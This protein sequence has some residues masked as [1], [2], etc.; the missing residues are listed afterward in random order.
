MDAS[1]QSH[2]CAPLAALLYDTGSIP[3]IDELIG[4]AAGSNEFALSHVPPAGEGWA[5]VLRDG[6]TFDLRGLSG[7]PI[8]PAPAI[9]LALGIDC[10]SLGDMSALLIYPGPHLAGAQRLLPVIRVAAALAISLSRI[11]RVRGICWIPARNAVDPELFERAV[12]PWL[13]GGPFP[14]LAL[15][16]LHRLPDEGIA[17]EGLKFLIG[18]EFV[19]NS[20]GAKSAEHLGRAALRLVDWLV[21]HGPITKPTEAILA[22]TGAVLVE[23]RDSTSIVAR[24]A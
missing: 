13:E 3:G 24:C 2:D 5:E 4:A 7:G 23:A 10:A 1:D 22:G 15:V 20:D 9:G 21:A 8:L 12:N 6:L 14:A 16:A 17:S 19:L 18:Q 11:G